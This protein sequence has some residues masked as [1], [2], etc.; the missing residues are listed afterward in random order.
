MKNIFTNNNLKGILGEDA[1]EVKKHI[2]DYV[3]TD[4][5]LEIEFAKALDAS[6]E[7]CVYA[8]LPRGFLY[9]LL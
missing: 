4:S 2:Y 1:I 9:L 5:K 3:V 8:K 7:V 6:K